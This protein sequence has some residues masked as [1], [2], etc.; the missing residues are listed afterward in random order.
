MFI[1]LIIGLGCSMKGLITKEGNKQLSKVALYIVNPMLIF[2]SYQDCEYSSTLLKGLLWS[3]LL[4]GISFGV[5]I[6]LSTLI[7]SQ[8]RPEHS[9]ERFSV[10]YSNCGFIGMPLIRGIYGTEGVLYLT[11]YITLFNILVWTH[12]YMTMKESRDFKSFVKAASSPSVIAVFIGLVF[13]LAQIRLPDVLHTSLQYVS[14][15]NTPLA[16]LIA[17]SATAQTNIIK[18]LKNKALYM[19]SVYKLLALPL[20]AFLLVHFLPAPH[21]VKM[22]V[23]IASACPVATTGT[24]FAIQFDKNPE[25]CSEFFAV[26][27]LLSGIT[28]PIVTMLGE[29]L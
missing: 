2:M 25:R 28:L 23:L 10:V 17:G 20:V 18:A 24:M 8:K 9:L 5:M 27:T 13:Y 1:I 22:V 4:S 6:L 29:M 16:M 3:F 14:D 15:M 11:A 12:G 7:I 21:M 26:T 19:V